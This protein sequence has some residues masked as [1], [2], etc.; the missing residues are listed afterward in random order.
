M[1][2]ADKP[3][4]AIN[5]PSPESV[6]AFSRDGHWIIFNSDRPQGGVGGTDIWV[7]WRA[8]THDDFGWRPAGG[9]GPGVNSPSGDSVG[10]YFEN[11]EADTPLLF[12]SSNRP[13]MGAAP[14]GPYVSALAGEEF[15]PPTL[16]TE[17]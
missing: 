15:G 3:G 10:S 6:P 11:K 9:P 4:A 12:F 13:L 7:S 2:P 5:P 16:V 14:G 1:G 8:H 17:R